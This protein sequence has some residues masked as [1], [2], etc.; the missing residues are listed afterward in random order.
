MGDSSI[1]RVVIRLG[2][3]TAFLDPGER[4]GT[5]VYTWSLV[6]RLAGDPRIELVVFSRGGRLGTVGEIRVRSVATPEFRSTPMRILW[7]Q[8][9]LGR[10]ATAEGVDV[11]WNP[12]YV[13]PLRPRVPSVVTIHDMY[14][15]EFPEALS[16]G[17]RIYYRWFVP[18]SAKAS[19]AVIAV[20]TNT[21]SD[22][23]RHI[24]GVEGRL[25]IIHEAP[26]DMAY[27]RDPHVALRPYFLVAASVTRNKNIEAV[28][29]ALSALTSAGHDIDVVVAGGDP[30][31]ILAELSRHSRVADR[32]KLMPGISD[33]DLV[34][35][36]KGAVAL[37]APSHYEGFNLPVLEAQMAGTP[38]VASA[39]GAL[40]EVLGESALTI[41]PDDP[42]TLAAAMSSLL[43]SE[44]LRVGLTDK[45]L[46]NVERF[47]WSRAADELVDVVEHIALDRA[48]LEGGD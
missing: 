10:L 31:G 9:R 23:A 7:E 5:G 48:A 42:D 25:H 17:R 34:S 29:S 11:L 35:L 6:E 3:N 26:R 47:S 41:D 30:F 38:V 24:D 12:G 14:Y 40:E 1:G 19:A 22:I 46:K 32:L 4:S 33:D 44:R 45:G 18:R 16:A 39:A 2:V 28:E 36:L 20:S 37:L 43:G 21:A 27:D 13:G 8:T 15:A